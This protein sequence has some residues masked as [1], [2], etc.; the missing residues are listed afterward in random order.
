L[1]GEEV[2]ISNA[3]LRFFPPGKESGRG[4]GIITGTAGYR[5]AD[6]TISADLVGAALP[7]ENFERLQSERFPVGRQVS[8]QLKA[9]GPAKAPLGEGTFRVVDLRV[10]QEVIGSFD[11]ELTSDGH[12][13]HLELS[14]AMSTGEISGGY[15]LGLAD[16]YPLSGKISVKNID[17]DPFLV[18]ALRLG[19]FGGHANAGGDISLSGSV[20]KPESIVVEATF[21]RLAFTYANVRLENVGPVRFRSSKQSLEIDPATLRV[22]DTHLQIAGSWQFTGRRSVG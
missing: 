21:S 18:T 3:E 12:A 5:H 2:R 15:T 9:S 20:K 1:S 13:A 6:G 17:L 11:G 16:P 8:F 19:K 10:G 22:T 14:S 7:L 4:A